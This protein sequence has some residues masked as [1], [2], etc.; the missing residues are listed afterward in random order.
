MS[1][2]EPFTMKLLQDLAVYLSL[3]VLWLLVKIL[4][5]RLMMWLGA[6]LGSTMGLFMRS[7]RNVARINIALCF[8]E[9][10]PD[11]RRAILREHF[12]N[13]GR[14]LFETGISWFASERFVRQLVT[15]EGVANLESALEAGRGALLIGGHFTTLDISCRAL[16]TAIDFDVSY[17][18]FGIEPLDAQVIKGRQ[19]GAGLAIAKDNV[20]LLLKRLKQNRTVWIAVDQADT[21]QGSV[22]ALFFG[23]LAP[24]SSSV[25]RI[26]QSHGCAISPLFCARRADGKGYLLRIEE[27]LQNFPSGDAAADAERLNAVMERHVREIPAQY[28]WIHRR[29]KG[30]PD[31][32]GMVS[33]H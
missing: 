24:S 2:V 3:A 5:Y 6:M 28:Y 20:R 33:R 10:R 7:R 29:F 11:D 19:R 16:G 14:G 31:P 4:P 30:H 1:R 21:S 13:L 15:V 18:P 12:R 26:A 25:G 22:P 23:H 32:Y 9:A 27:P 17:R 8:P